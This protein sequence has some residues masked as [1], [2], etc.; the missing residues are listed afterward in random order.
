MQTVYANMANVKT[1]IYTDFLFQSNR[2]MN[3]LCCFFY[4]TAIVKVLTGPISI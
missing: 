4:V 1:K 3:Q 2:L